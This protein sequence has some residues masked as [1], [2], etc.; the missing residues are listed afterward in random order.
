MPATVVY[1]L[2]RTEDSEV[3]HTRYRENF[4][5]ARAPAG[6]VSRGYDGNDQI[7]N[8]LS[9]YHPWRVVTTRQ[10]HSGANEFG[11]SSPSRSLA[12]GLTGSR[13]LDEIREP[14]QLSALGTVGD[15]EFPPRESRGGWK[16]GSGDLTGTPRYAAADA[17]IRNPAGYHSITSTRIFPST[18]YANVYISSLGENQ[19]SSKLPPLTSV[20]GSSVS[21]RNYFRDT[22]V[23]RPVSHPLSRNTGSAVG[24]GLILSGRNFYGFSASFLVTIFEQTS[25]RELQLSWRNFDPLRD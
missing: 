3:R 14:R 2:C 19:S 18:V 22:R 9:C 24:A 17:C 7:S 4:H 21:G 16:R 20:Y 23:V 13:G 12:P 5:Q 10:L 8:A 11:F 25:E 6:C 15:E 1:I